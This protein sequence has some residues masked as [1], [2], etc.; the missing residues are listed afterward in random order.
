[1]SVLHDHLAEQI[2]GNQKLN[3]L[4]STLIFSMEDGLTTPVDKLVGDWSNL[5]PGQKVTI[6]WSDPFKI[7]HGFIF[8]LPGFSGKKLLDVAIVQIP[9]SSNDEN[10]SG[11][12]LLKYLAMF[13]D[14]VEIEESYGF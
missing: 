14:T 8:T 1:M 3:Q 5:E 9:R 6:T 13:A 7:E 12:M 4:M 11:W 10:L 2:K